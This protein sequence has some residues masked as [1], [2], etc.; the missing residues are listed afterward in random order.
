MGLFDGYI[1]PEQF[2]NGGGLLGRLLALQ[3]FQGQ[4]QPGSEFDQ[5]SSVPQTPSPASTLSPL[6]S[7]YGQPAQAP[8]NWQNAMAT[9]GQPDPAGLAA[10]PPRQILLWRSTLRQGPWASRCR[11]CLCPA[12]PKTTP[13]VIG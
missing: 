1:D 12:L 11:R 8:V 9:G 13:S 10:S 6:L 5:A 2:G 4:Y 3:Q 7:N